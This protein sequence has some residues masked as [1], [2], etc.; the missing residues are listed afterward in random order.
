MPANKNSYLCNTHAFSAVF[1]VLRT[2]RDMIILHVQLNSFNYLKKIYK[3]TVENEPFWEWAFNGD[4]ELPSGEK[5]EGVVGKGFF[6]NR[7]CFST[8]SLTRH[9]VD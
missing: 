1:I 7:L 4:I 8:A 2:S 9:A 5:S 6:S 3:E